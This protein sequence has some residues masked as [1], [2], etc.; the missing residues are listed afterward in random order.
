MREQQAK[1]GAKRLLRALLILVPM[2]A[3]LLAASPFLL[4]L[5][6]VRH[7]SSKLKSAKDYSHAARAAEQ[8]ANTRESGLPILLTSLRK[9]EKAYIRAAVASAL[10]PCK[11]SSDVDV[12]QALLEAALHDPDRTVRVTA[13]WGRYYQRGEKPDTLAAIGEACSLQPFEAGYRVKHI[14]ATKFRIREAVESLLAD[15]AKHPDDCVASS[16]FS[17][18]RKIVGHDL[19]DLPQLARWSGRESVLDIP[20]MKAPIL[21]EFKSW[22]K[23]H[24]SEFRSLEDWAKGKVPVLPDDT[25]KKA[26]P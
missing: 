18:F 7:W 9:S 11:N 16:A 3:V 25:E 2:V 20:A 8:L 15:A 6:R 22:W 24:R 4:D 26:Q 1:N 21:A 19:S 10:A 17:D 13:G 23:T 14:L 12:D 5:W